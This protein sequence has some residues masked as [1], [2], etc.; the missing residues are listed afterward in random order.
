MVDIILVVDFIQLIYKIPSMFLMMVSVHIIIKEI[1]NKNISFNNQFYTI[2][3]CKLTN[4]IVYI[5]TDFIFIKLP[6]W[7]FFNTFL[8]K[9]AWIATIF[10]I[11]AALQI[12]FLFFTT[13][14]ISIN[15]CVAV[16]YPLSY[17]IYFSK[18]KIVIILLSF[19]ILSTMIGFGN[20]FFNAKYEKFE[21]YGYFV[22]ILKSKNVIYYQIF[23]RIFLYGLISIIML[24]LYFIKKLFEDKILCIFNL[25]FNASIFFPLYIQHN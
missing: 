2:I 23:Y 25:F 19:F 18:S 17:K 1:K 3:V 6:N 16:K 5:L 7:G 4:E 20:I 9:N 11:L 13:L 12:A 14:L 8:E 21:L 15:R 22:P 24:K 10:F